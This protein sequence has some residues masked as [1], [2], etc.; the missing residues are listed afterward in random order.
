MNNLKFKTLE[1]IKF[2]GVFGV[3]LIVMLMVFFNFHK[4]FDTIG[5]IFCFGTSLL[6]MLMILLFY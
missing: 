4:E 6:L 3:P 1:A 2:I 5:L